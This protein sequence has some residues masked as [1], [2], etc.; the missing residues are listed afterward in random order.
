MGVRKIRRER[1]PFK[2]SNYKTSH[3]SVFD[4]TDCKKFGST[5]INLEICLNYILFLYCGRIHTI[6]NP[7]R[8]K[9]YL[10]SVT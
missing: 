4:F 9:N 3:K 6:F 7:R 1:N 8:G 10:P 2:P 5:Q